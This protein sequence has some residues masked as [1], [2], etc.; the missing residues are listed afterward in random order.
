[1]TKTRIG[2]IGVGHHG[3][4]HA[5]N[6]SLMSDVS[7]VGVVDAHAETARHVA[8]LCQTKPFSEPGDLLDKVDAV[9]VAVPT[10]NHA[11]VAG[12]F[13]KRGVSTLVEKPISFSVDQ[14]RDMVRLA[15]QN[16]A[17]LMV[18]HIERFNP[19]WAAV[20]S[21]NIKPRFIDVAR[22]SR[23]P[24]RSLDVSVVFDVMIHDI[25]LVRAVARSKV[26]KVEAIGSASISPSL[27]WASVRIEFEN[28]T[29]AN[30]HASRIH[31][32]TERKMTLRSDRASLEIDFLRRTSTNHQ[33]TA[34]ARELLGRNMGPLTAE[35]K[36]LLWREMSVV[37]VEAHAR[38]VEPLRL[39][40]E[41]FVSAVR[42]GRDPIVTGEDG[43]ESVAIATEI[44]RVI[45]ATPIS[46][47]E[48]A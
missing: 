27:D 41:E 22:L 5:R 26:R 33:L 32:T 3:R 43:L 46:L 28:H 48:A 9:V 44:E 10:A 13:L 25:D 20:Q 7:L 39:E 37:H 19:A 11:S 16:N 38:E 24:F 31:H 40:L 35:E 23:F 6:L 8:D 12:P 36:E 4:H 29:L 30:L 34:G 14:A 45:N 1:M 47:R 21:E 17:V 2:V 18:G 42:E 15:R